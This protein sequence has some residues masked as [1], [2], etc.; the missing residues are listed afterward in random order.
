MIMILIYALL[1]CLLN[2]SVVNIFGENYQLLVMFQVNDFSSFSFISVSVMSNTS[3]ISSVNTG[4][5]ITKTTYTTYTFQFVMKFDIVANIIITSILALESFYR[6]NYGFLMLIC[7]YFFWRF[8]CIFVLV[9]ISKWYVLQPPIYPLG[10]IRQRHLCLWMSPIG[11]KILLFLF[12]ICFC[13]WTW[14]IKM[15]WIELNYIDNR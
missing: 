15:H 14:W 6:Y 9:L 4:D 12:C 8:L 5:F 11:F 1:I 10:G 13:I 3:F 7:T 2:M